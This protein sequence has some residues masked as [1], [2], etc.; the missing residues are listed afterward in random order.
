VAKE[1]ADKKRRDTVESKMTLNLRG[2]VFD[3]TKY[4]VLNGDSTYFSVLLSS[5]TW[6]LDA[7][8]ELFINRCGNGFDR[9]LDYVSTGV[10]SNKG[11]NWYDEEWYV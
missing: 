1:K 2:T 11:V 9:T 3:T 7:N 10:L 5:T 6:E 4:T 8:G